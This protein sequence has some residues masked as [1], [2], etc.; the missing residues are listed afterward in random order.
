MTIVEGFT[1]TL[2]EIYKRSRVSADRGS[3]FQIIRKNHIEN[4]LFCKSMRFWPADVHVIGKDIAWFHTV[5]W[6]AMLWSA[7]VNC[8]CRS[9]QGVPDYFKSVVE[10]SDRTL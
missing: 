7:E 6:P 3:I 2:A 9:R 8:F 4:T 5:I 10:A 1:N